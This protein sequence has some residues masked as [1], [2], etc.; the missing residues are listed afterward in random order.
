[1]DRY[2]EDISKL[3]SDFKIGL[4]EFIEYISNNTLQDNKHDTIQV[5]FIETMLNV[6][7]DILKYNH[8]EKNK[9]KQ[10]LKRCFEKEVI[11]ILCSRNTSKDGKPWCWLEL[12]MHS[13]IFLF[14]NT[15]TYI[16]IFLQ[17][18][19]N[20]VFNAHGQGSKSCS[21]GM[22]E[23]L[24]NIH[25]QASEIYISCFSKS[26]AEIV[27]LNID[28]IQQFNPSDSS[29]KDEH[30]TEKWIYEFNFPSN[31]VDFTNQP[32]KYTTLD[33]KYTYHKLINLLNNKADLPLKSVSGAG[34]SDVE[35]IIIDY[36][37]TPE[38][39][40]EWY[41]DIKI[42]VDND[43]IST[44]DHVL[45]HYI[46]FIIDY[47]YK[48]YNLTRDT[49]HTENK[50]KFDRYRI[51]LEEFERKPLEEA[52][53]LMC[54]DQINKETLTE[55]FSGGF[56]RSKS[57]KS[58][59]KRSTSKKLTHKKL[60]GSLK[61]IDIE[62][63]GESPTSKRVSERKKPILKLSL[64][65]RLRRYS[66]PDS[67]RSTSLKSSPLTPQTKKNLEITLLKAIFSIDKDT[68]LE[69][70]K[71]EPDYNTFSKFS[72]NRVYIDQQQKQE[73]EQEK[74]KEKEQ[75]EKDKISIISFP[76]STHIKYQKNKYEIKQ[77]WKT[78]YK[79][80]QQVK[81]NYEYSINKLKETKPEPTSPEQTK[82]EPTSPEQTNAEPKPKAEPTSPDDIITI[83]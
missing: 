18:Y 74:E 21:L 58:R 64:K 3:I 60:T 5:L 7:S 82:P 49:I 13:M 47:K 70:F 54:N 45:D 73:K 55:Y 26:K 1:M 36:D 79:K 68:F 35:D 11:I 12:V 37:I 15:Q 17:T 59:S 28:D 66:K 4:T 20:E 25:S 31:D 56:S 34:S 46:N 52:I 24:V 75:Q 80:Y 9:L 40:G 39:R 33:T 51:H 41:D 23:R 69:Y 63:K 27:E 38:I 22:V 71:F 44:L 50:K 32:Y 67:E 57:K 16:F 83:L 8:D 65:R 76:P 29:I 53:L 10:D 2:S 30:I 72:K 81:S 19:F 43:E 6:L 14:N 42:K 78:I 48:Q 61:L 77:Y 62:P